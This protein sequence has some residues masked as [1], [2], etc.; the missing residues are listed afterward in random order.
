MGKKKKRRQHKVDNQL[1]AGLL[2]LTAALINLIAT[3]LNRKQSQESGAQASSRSYY[4]IPYRCT[5]EWITLS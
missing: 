4:N 5:Q 2:S 1:A 3:L